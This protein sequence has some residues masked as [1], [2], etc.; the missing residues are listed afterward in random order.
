VRIRIVFLQDVPPRHLAGDVREVAAGYARNYLIPHRLAAPAVPEQL[1]RIGKIKKVADERRTR[2]T[3]DMQVLA[4][5]LQGKTVVLKARSGEG[6]RLYGSVTNL[7]IAAELSK[8][9]ERE[10]DRRTILL[11]EPIKELGTFQVPIRLYHNIAPVI[12]VVVEA[13]GQAP[14]AASAQS[15]DSEPEISASDVEG[16]EADVRGEDPTP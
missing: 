1:K 8:V 3:Q 11:P 5:L 13:E 4:E 12:T 15:L 16:G 14:A 10:I 2:E 9:V 7:S 6:G